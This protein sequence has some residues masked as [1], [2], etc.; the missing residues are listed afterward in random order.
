MR[1]QALGFLILSNRLIKLI[2]LMENQPEI[3]VRL[4]VLWFQLKSVTIVLHRCGKISF[5]AQRT[6]HVVV[7]LGIVGQSLE[8]FLK[9]VQRSVILGV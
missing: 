7:R 2:L 9:C 1:R 3:G 5:V 4:P 8:R 6:A